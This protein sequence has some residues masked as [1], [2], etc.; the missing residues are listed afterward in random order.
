MADDRGILLGVD[1]SDGYTQLSCIGSTG[2]LFSVP[3]GEDPLRFRVPTALCAVEHGREWLFGDDAERH[4]DTDDCYRVNNLVS[5]ACRGETTVIFG[6]EYTPDMLLERFFKRLFASVKDRA[7]CSVIRGMT[8]TVRKPNE[9]F[10][11]HLHSALEP[12]GVRPEKIRV[13]SYLDS[14]MY[15]AVSQNKDIW[16]NDVALFDFTE[17]GFVYYRLSF[18]RKQIPITIV[19]DRIDLSDR[20]SMPMLAPDDRD[21]LLFNFEKLMNEMLHKQIISTLFFTGDGFETAWADDVLK[22]LCAG[23]R[24]F[25]GQNLYVKG[26]GYAASLFFDGGADRYLPVSDGVLKADIAMRVYADGGIREIPLAA[27]GEP[28]E[29]AGADTDIILDDTNEL[30]LMIRSVLR[31]DCIC[32]IMTL[33]SLNVRN[34]RTTRLN[35]RLRFPDR[36]TCVIT[37]RDIGFGDIYRT[38]HR[39]WEQ[40][41]KI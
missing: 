28:A 21:R 9:S 25:R 32:A 8:V 6:R 2:E 31:K 30:D 37:V 27:I 38:S 19:A 24:I 5:L 22:K 7:D 16:A 39:I 18:G 4:P 35:V 14:F 17:K 33:D 29:T 1:I 15:Y 34:D 40:V 41:I 13:I 20:I 12:L 11:R 3:L 10:T 23:R 26:A 36:D